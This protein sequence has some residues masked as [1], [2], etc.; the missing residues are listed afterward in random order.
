[1]YDFER[2]FS[3]FICKEV[4]VRKVPYIP[5]IQVVN[6]V[7]PIGNIIRRAGY[8]SLEQRANVAIIIPCCGSKTYITN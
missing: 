4:F 6:K 3:Y 5:P 7:R 2:D 8:I 1:M